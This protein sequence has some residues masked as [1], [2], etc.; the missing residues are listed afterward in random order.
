MKIFILAV[1]IASSTFLRIYDKNYNV[2]GHVEEGKKINRI[3]DKNHNVIGYVEER[4]KSNRIF[5]EK[6]NRIG[7]KEYR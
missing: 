2:I 1:L 3:F 7:N 4:K 6:W 5:D